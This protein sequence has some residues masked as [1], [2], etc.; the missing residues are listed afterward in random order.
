MRL[1][2]VR[3]VEKFKKGD[4]VNVSLRVA[5]FLIKN[6]YAIQS[7]DMTDNDYKVK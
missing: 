7:K 4:I 3:S 6:G 1:R 2:I 5:K